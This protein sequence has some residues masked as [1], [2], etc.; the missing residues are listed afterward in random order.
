M[1][2]VIWSGNSRSAGSNSGPGTG[3]SY[4]GYSGSGSS[5]VSDSFGPAGAVNVG[6]FPSS[7]SAP[8]ANFD[9]RLYGNNLVGHNADFNSFDDVFKTISSIIQNTFG[10]GA[11]SR[12]NENYLKLM[13]MQNEYNTNSAAKAMKFNREMAERQMAFQQYNAD[14]TYQRAVKDLKAAG[15]NPVL[16]ALNG[17]P[18]PN[19][20]SAQGVA[21]SSASAGYDDGY[22]GISSIVGQLISNLPMLSIAS[23]V[24]G[25][26][27]QVKRF[28]TDTT[29]NVGETVK[30]VS[31][32]VDSTINNFG[33]SDGKYYTPFQV[34]K[35]RKVYGP[36]KNESPKK[37]QT[38][39]YQTFAGRMYDRI[40]HHT[41]N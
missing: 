18:S 12:N 23:A 33:N 17:A 4:S 37:Y 34:K 2:D 39:P 7:L 27:P 1:A 40:F 25:L 28:L 16:A 15:L 3:I 35:D 9:N 10:G 32:V 26:L 20:A 41:Y 36:V 21:M 14:T 22:N 29:K 11:Q 24:N 8:Y 5:G 19:G 13:E 31:D 38:Y 6:Y 30:N